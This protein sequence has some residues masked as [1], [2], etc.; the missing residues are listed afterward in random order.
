MSREN[1]LT[2][3]QVADILGIKVSN[4]DYLR[5]TRRLTGIRGY[6]HSYMFKSDEVIALKQ[7]RE[8]KGK[9]PPFGLYVP[10]FDED[11]R[12]LYSYKPQQIDYPIY[13]TSKRYFV[14]STGYIISEYYNRFEYQAICPVDHGYLQVSLSIGEGKS[15]DLLVH[16]LV[17]GL[18]CPN[19]LRKNEV[20]H[21][22]FNRANNDYRNLIWVTKEEHVKLHELYKDGQ[23]DEYKKL[24]RKIQR[25]NKKAMKDYPVIVDETLGTFYQVTREGYKL[26]AKTGAFPYAKDIV[27]EWAISNRD[28]TETD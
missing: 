3:K 21:I 23:I 7:E 9:E 5:R 17:A 8:A 27:A 1:L 12:P 4:V 26:Y 24:I 20:H 10:K 28:Y 2:K 13:F 6:Y 19:G 14:T 25:A 15:K 18:Y 11:L 22:D 16:R